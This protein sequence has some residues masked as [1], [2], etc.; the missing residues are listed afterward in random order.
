MSSHVGLILLPFY[1]PKTAI[2]NPNNFFPL[3]N[4]WKNKGSK[5][6]GCLYLELMFPWE[7]LST[8]EQ[9]LKRVN[10][11]NGMLENNLKELLI[12]YSDI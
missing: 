5:N 4:K 2:K 1:Q 3:Y 9:G 8:S 10:L 11:A 6:L 12:N 7:C